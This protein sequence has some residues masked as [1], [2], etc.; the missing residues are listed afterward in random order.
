MKSLLFVLL[1]C[2]FSFVACEEKDEKQTVIIETEPILHGHWILY[3]RGYS[4]GVGYEIEKVNTNPPSRITLTLDKEFSSNITG[5]DKFK[6]YR[7]VVDPVN[8]MQVLV[9]YEE[10]PGDNIP[11]VTTLKHSY[12]IELKNDNLK[13]YFRYCIE[14]CHMAFKREI[15]ND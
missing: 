2:T 5:L 11:D 13:L 3:E 14:G 12:F 8:D 10:D 4:P 1:L 9:L 7:T 6:F 15:L